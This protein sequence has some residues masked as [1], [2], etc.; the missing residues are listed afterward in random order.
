MMNAM[1]LTHFVLVLALCSAVLGL[2]PSSAP[3][4]E[5]SSC[6]GSVKGQDPQPIEEPTL[7]PTADLLTVPT[8]SPSYFYGGK[9]KGKG[10]GSQRTY[11]PSS[12][13]TQG[14]NSH[15]SPSAPPSS[16]GETEGGLVGMGRGKG[17]RG[18]NGSGHV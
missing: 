17:G 16:I 12:A 1:Q 18:G 11:D 4:Y 2:E 14:S 5:H 15:K 7:D 9:G 3:A 8:E 6:V 13:P 10:K